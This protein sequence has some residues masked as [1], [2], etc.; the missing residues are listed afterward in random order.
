MR[1]LIPATAVLCALLLAGAAAAQRTHERNAMRLTAPGAGLHHLTQLPPA[2][3]KQSL[4]QN[5][6]FQRLSPQQQNR[7]MARLKRLNSM[8]PDKQQ[9]LIRQLRAFAKLSPHQRAG[10]RQIYRQYRQMPARDRTT[11]RATY[12]ALR[13]L[14][15]SQRAQRLVAPGLQQKLTP[16]E[17]LTLRHALALH[18]PANLVAGAGKP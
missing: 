4:Q 15:S 10:L 8:P 2:Q 17:V 6:D 9:R 13:L 14:P 1:R 7:I 5:P 16:P 11:F 3:R 18:L 12:N